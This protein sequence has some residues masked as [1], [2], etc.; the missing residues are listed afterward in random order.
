MQGA[1]ERGELISTFDVAAKARFS[2]SGYSDGRLMTVRCGVIK[3]GIAE[4]GRRGIVAGLRYPGDPLEPYRI[5]ERGTVFLEAA[6][7][8][9]ICVIDLTAVEHDAAASAHILARRL[10]QVG[11]LLRS[12][13]RE[14]SAMMGQ[15][16]D[17]RLAVFLLQMLETPAHRV[18]DAQ[19]PPGTVLL[20][21]Y[22]SRGEIAEC[23]GLAMETVSRSLTRMAEDGLIAKEGR[24]AL[25]IKDP[26][27]LRRRAGLPAGRSV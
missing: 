12:A 1:I 7:A 16:P 5:V 26:T 25:R 21:L 13:E 18:A 6:V 17:T 4:E 22:L 15:P 9:T 10:D 24:N 8:S 2:V 23:L 3:F 27:A 19:G 11:A 14:R 20:R